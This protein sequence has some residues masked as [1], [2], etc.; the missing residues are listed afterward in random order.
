MKFGRVRGIRAFF[1][2]GP[3]RVNPFCLCWTNLQHW[4]YLKLEKKEVSLPLFISILRSSACHYQP[5][6]FSDRVGQETPGLLVVGRQ[7]GISVNPPYSLLWEDD[8]HEAAHLTIISHNWA[9]ELFVRMWDYQ[10][11]DLHVCVALSWLILTRSPHTTLSVAATLRTVRTPQQQQ[12]MGQFYR[13]KYL[14]GPDSF[15]GKTCE[16]S[17]QLLFHISWLFWIMTFSSYNV[18][19]VLC[20]G[21]PWTNIVVVIFVLQLSNSQRNEKPEQ[22]QPMC[23][24]GTK[25]DKT[26]RWLAKFKVFSPWQANDADTILPV[27]FGSRSRRPLDHDVFLTSPLNPG[28]SPHLS[29]L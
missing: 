6:Q 28:L 15:P 17:Q 27:Q 29:E 16:A 7:G 12:T 1:S 10:E 23:R 21:K 13:L 22:T 8:T 26:W 2:C 20:E 5:Q 18:V 25:N 9:K 24:V 11:K 14:P 3:N 19:L 4:I